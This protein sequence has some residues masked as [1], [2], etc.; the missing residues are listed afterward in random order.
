MAFRLPH[1]FYGVRIPHDILALFSAEQNGPADGVKRAKWQPCQMGCSN[2]CQ[3][4]VQVVDAM[5]IARRN[6][7]DA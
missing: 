1:L 6:W 7:H 3:R 5:F 2:V 4:I